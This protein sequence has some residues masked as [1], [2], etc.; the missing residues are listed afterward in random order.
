MGFFKHHYENLGKLPG[1]IPGNERYLPFHYIDKT[2]LKTGNDPIG[3][4]VEIESEK[5]TKIV[6][7]LEEVRLKHPVQYCFREVIRNVFEHGETSLCVVFAQKWPRGCLEIAVLDRGRGI[8]ASLGERYDLT[9]DYDALLHAIS[10]GVSRVGYDE[11]LDKVWGNSGYGLYV[12]SELARLAGMFILCSGDY[13][14]FINQKSQK[15]V[16]YPFQGTAVR[17]FLKKP[18]GKNI[19]DIINMIIERGSRTQKNGSRKFPSKSTL[20]I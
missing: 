11:N 10:P 1:D 19:N 20:K 8:R 9:D 13:G 15:Q 5:L 12:L 4:A 18:K 14:L 16:P 6:L 2:E 17:L 7:S 3:K